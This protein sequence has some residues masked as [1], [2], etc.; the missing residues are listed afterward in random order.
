M[1]GNRYP[2]TVTLGKVVAVC[3]RGFI[4][5]AVLAAVIFGISWFVFD[6]G[7]IVSEREAA[8]QLAITV[9]LNSHGEAATDL[10]VSTIEQRKQLAS[11][12]LEAR[13]ANV[14]GSGTD[15][16][17]L[18]DEQAIKVHEV[19]RSGLPIQFTPDVWHWKDYW[20]FFSN[21]GLWAVV[22]FAFGT[23][24]F[25]SWVYEIMFYSNDH[26]AD[27]P[28]KR[29]WPWVFTLLCGPVAWVVM[30]GSAIKR[31]AGENR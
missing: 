14:L 6:L 19:A 7:K 4:K 3:G 12:L 1:Y 31:W 10:S 24:T 21:W 8:N 30:V 16:L 13:S 20:N 11:R 9:M 22:W 28:W 29:V 2:Q 15:L 23:A 27:L 5:I 18:D 25:M 17:H 26:F